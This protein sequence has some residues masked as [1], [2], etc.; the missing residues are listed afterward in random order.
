VVIHNIEKRSPGRTIIYLRKK[1]RRKHYVQ[2]CGAK[3]CHD[4]RFRKP[5]NTTTEGTEMPTAKNTTIAPITTAKKGE[6]QT[7][8][9][10]KETTEGTTDT[11]TEFPGKLSSK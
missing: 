9:S 8:A 6:P 10:V 7:E 1:K 11:S 2:C 3:R 4:G 5:K